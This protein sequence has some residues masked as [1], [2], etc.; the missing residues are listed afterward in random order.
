[1][2][3][4]NERLA[5]VVRNE[6]TYALQKRELA[7]IQSR[8]GQRNYYHDTL[9]LEINKLRAELDRLRVHL[10]VEF[11]PVEATFKAVPIRNMRGPFDNKDVDPFTG[12]PLTGPAA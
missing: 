6:V 10:N 12:T 8:L 5:E 9:T 11:I 2:W 3:I 4:S 7:E 1:M